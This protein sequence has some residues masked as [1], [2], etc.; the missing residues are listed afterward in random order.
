MQP[1][2]V[3][4]ELL[5]VL[6][7]LDLLPHAIHSEQRYDDGI[8]LVV[9]PALTDGTYFCRNEIRKKVE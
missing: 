7:A 9:R 1:I 8:Y 4:L 5:T 3:L 6:P 2:D